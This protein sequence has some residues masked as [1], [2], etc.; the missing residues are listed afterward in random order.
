MTIEEAKLKA[1]V[2]C[3]PASGGGDYD[4]EKIRADLED[5]EVEWIETKEAGDASEAAKQWNEGLLIVAGG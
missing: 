2:I 4:P 3:N 1:R 5:F